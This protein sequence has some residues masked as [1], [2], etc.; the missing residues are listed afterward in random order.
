[1]PK[2]YCWIR[3]FLCSFSVVHCFAF[4]L[5]GCSAVCLLIHSDSSR[6]SSTLRL[7][8]FLSLSA[9]MCLLSL[10]RSFNKSVFDFSH[11]NW[12]FCDKC[13]VVQKLAWARSEAT[14]NKATSNLSKL[15]RAEQMGLPMSWTAHFTFSRFCPA[16]YLNTN[17]KMNSNHLTCSTIFCTDKKLYSIG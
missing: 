9:S 4:L 12:M 1:M 16:L 14:H 13:C 2:V 8:F 15:H 17:D 7:L 5:T 11:W 10:L 3:W 6:V